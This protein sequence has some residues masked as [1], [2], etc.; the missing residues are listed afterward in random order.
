MPDA[1]KPASLA[2]ILGSATRVQR[3]ATVC[4]AGHL[5]DQIE[6]LERRLA[7][8]TAE[9][10][11]SD[12]LGD[13]ASEERL[14]LA[15]QIEALQVEMKAHEHSFTFSAVHPKEW[16]DLVAQHPPREEVREP[17]N[18]DTFPLAACLASLRQV[19]GADVAAG[20]L[21]LL[22]QLWTDVLNVG[23]RTD[24]FNA[25]WDANTGSVSVPFSALASATL[26]STGEK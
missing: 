7:D 6:N 4:V 15:A 23:Q 9:A 2:D 18:G 14:D 16:S 17:F 11:S 8:L 24:L 20:D 25:A 26:R 19:N 5:N 1:D 12:S 21:P 22:E 13:P 3:T 10:R